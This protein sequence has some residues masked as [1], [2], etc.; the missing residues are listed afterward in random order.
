MWN[1]ESSGSAHGSRNEVSRRSLTGSCLAKRYTVG[2]AAAS[3][4]TS[5]AT[6]DPPAKSMNQPTPAIPMAVPRSGSFK[7]RREQAPVIISGKAKPRHRFFVLSWD[8]ERYE[9]R[10]MTS[11]SLANSEGCTLIG[12]TP[13]HLLD[14]PTK[15]PTPGTRT[16]A[17]AARDT[18][19]RSPDSRP[20]TW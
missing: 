1:P 18:T 13:S 8:A 5:A 6:F 20:H 11:D 19:M 4:A 14:P 10:K 16:R 7:I 12:P 15:T 3:V 9:A 17:S 2:P